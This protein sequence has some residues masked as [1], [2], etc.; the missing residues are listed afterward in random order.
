MKN[1][2]NHLNFM[3]VSHKLIFDTV[4]DKT[5]GRGA[6]EW[7]QKCFKNMARINYCQTE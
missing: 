4:C 2:D 1:H 6:C 7:G 5:N 3:F